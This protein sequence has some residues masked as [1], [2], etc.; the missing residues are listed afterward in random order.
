MI[1]FFCHC[2]IGRVVFL[3]NI[4][5]T[6]IEKY[7]LVTIQ[8]NGNLSETLPALLAKT[9]FKKTHQIYIIDSKITWVL[10]FKKLKNIAICM[11]VAKGLRKDISHA[12][13]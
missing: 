3:T 13:L 4:R 2:N 11:K 1:C 9:G 6:C 10:Q 12:C 5:Y 8:R 7:L